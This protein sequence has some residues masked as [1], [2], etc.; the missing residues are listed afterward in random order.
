M[1]LRSCGGR[2]HT[3]PA[4]NRA[5]QTTSSA[6]TNLIPTARTHAILPP[7]RPDRGDGP[8]TCSPASRTSSAPSGVPLPLRQRAVR[9][10]DRRAGA[11]LR[12]SVDGAGLG[13]ARPD[14]RVWS[15]GRARR[16]GRNP[17]V[18]IHN[19]HPFRGDDAARGTPGVFQARR[20]EDAPAC[21]QVAEGGS[22]MTDAGRT[23]ALEQAKP[24]AS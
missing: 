12:R 13:P 18:A 8:V 24:V 1:L 5:R 22:A 16:R 23:L 4:I 2:V 14:S 17:R 9:L 7:S 19:Q 21:A 20:R 15:F 11:G 6:R 3:G 10:W